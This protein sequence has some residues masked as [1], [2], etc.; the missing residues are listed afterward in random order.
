MEDN[1]FWPE[2]SSFLA[3]TIDFTSKC[4]EM[5]HAK[6]SP[7]IFKKNHTKTVRRSA[8]KGS[9]FGCSESW[10]LREQR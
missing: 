7:R 4:A 6:I 8:C 9:S 3:E 5:A 1:T 10:F 2:R